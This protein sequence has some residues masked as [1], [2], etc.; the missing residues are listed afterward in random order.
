MMQTQNENQNTKLI[1]YLKRTLPFILTEKTGILNES[2]PD[3]RCL[4]LAGILSL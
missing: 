4:Q 1:E 2:I 3:T